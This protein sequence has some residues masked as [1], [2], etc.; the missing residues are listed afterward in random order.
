MPRKKQTE[1][2]PEQP[3]QDQQNEQQHG[4]QTSSDTIQ[5]TAQTVST[6][7]ERKLALDGQEAANVA[8]DAFNE[9]F[10]STCEERFS[11]F[12]NCLLPEL[13]ATFGR[14]QQR[15]TDRQVKRQNIITRIQNIAATVEATQKTLVASPMGFVDYE[16]QPQLEATQEVEE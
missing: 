2:Q 1:Q 12:V 13:Q 4:L 11:E 16:V 7:F 8:W 10:V 15:S 6:L 14:L 3:T 5:F 9:S